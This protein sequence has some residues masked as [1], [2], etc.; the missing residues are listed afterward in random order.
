MDGTSF[1]GA[2][3]RQRRHAAQLGTAGV[4]TPEIVVAGRHETPGYD[5]G[6]VQAAVEQARGEAGVQAALRLERDPAGLRVS[7]GAE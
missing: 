2:G 7:A 1:S 6:A 4:C 5:A 3:Q